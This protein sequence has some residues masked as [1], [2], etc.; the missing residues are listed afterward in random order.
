MCLC[1]CAC[2]RVRIFSRKFLEGQLTARR[3]LM[4]KNKMSYGAGDCARLFFV[5]CADSDG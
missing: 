4:K 2:L 1:V 5:C 3:R